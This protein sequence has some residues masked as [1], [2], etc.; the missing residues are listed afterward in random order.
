MKKPFAKN[1][2]GRPPALE[3]SES[4]AAVYVGRPMLH[5]NIFRKRISRI[6]GRP[7]PGDWVAVYSE[8]NNRDDENL[9]SRTSPQLFGYGIFNDRSE[10]AVRLYRWWGEIPD[11]PFWDQLLDRAV[12]LRREVLELDGFCDAY[13]VIHGEADG[14]PGLVVDRYGDCLSAEVFSLGMYQRADSILAGLEA[15]LGTRHRLIQTSPQF[16]SQEGVEAPMVPSL[17]LPDSVTIQEYGT[18][19]RVHFA[20]G[21]KTGFFCDQRD[22][23][24][25]LADFCRDKTVLDL[26]CY[27][28]GFSV[29]AAKLGG[30]AEVTGVDIDAEPLDWATKNANINQ[31]RVRFVQS[32]AF[33]FM[34]DMIRLKRQYDIV[35][36]DPP[37]LIRNRGEIEEGTKKHADLNRLAMQLVQPGG[38][39]LSCSCAGLLAES[40]F[41]QLIR[42][43]AKATGFDES[44]KPL[45]PRT[46]QILHRHGAAPDHPVV[47]HCPET[48][49]LKSVWMRVI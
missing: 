14:F 20:S 4:I 11:Q 13:R 25:R 10:I 2:T 43:A 37:K 46:V 21:H 39:M 12:S 23:R 28:G 45:P 35:V 33:G 40:T 48:E 36:L 27:S 26:C 41:V 24:K 17:N 22:N 49:Y 6:E 29:Q 1:T 38:I 47:A 31:V 44:G 7:R 42:S 8:E 30:A 3:K 34:R 9:D 19:F 18:K 32:D 15:R 5:P 16:S